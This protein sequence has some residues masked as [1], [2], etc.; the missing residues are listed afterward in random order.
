MSFSYTILRSLD[1]IYILR[2]WKLFFYFSSWKFLPENFTSSLYWLFVR[3]FFCYATESKFYKEKLH[4][5]FDF[6]P[7]H[8]LWK[9]R[10][11]LMN[12]RLQVEKF[13]NFFPWKSVASR[14]STRT[15]LIWFTICY[16]VADFGRALLLAFSRWQFFNKSHLSN[17]VWSFNAE[18]FRLEM[19]NVRG[20]RIKMSILNCIIFLHSQRNS[21]TSSTVVNSQHEWAAMRKKK[22]EM[23]LCK[24][25]QW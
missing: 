16:N 25:S 14:K 15:C 20:F 21:T 19:K 2:I 13:N 1:F 24:F 12:W 7:F 23:F 17:V 4:F 5:I 10:R 3:D 18:N 22:L 8:Q 9:S 6:S 11:W